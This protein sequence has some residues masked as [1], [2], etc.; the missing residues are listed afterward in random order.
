MGMN[1]NHVSF[2]ELD[3]TAWRI[4]ALFV[5]FIAGC[6]M[7]LHLVNHLMHVLDE[8]ICLITWHTSIGNE[9]ISIGGHGRMLIKALN[10]NIPVDLLIELL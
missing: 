8:G 3:E 2:G 7:M 4:S 9:T 1:H 5:D 10:C 6:N